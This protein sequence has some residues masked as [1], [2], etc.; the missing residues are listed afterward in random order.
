MVSRP[1]PT[2]IFGIHTCDVQ[3]TRLFDQIFSQGLP[4]SITAPGERTS[5][6]QH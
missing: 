2:V 1:E 5:I 6:H 4:T 3:A